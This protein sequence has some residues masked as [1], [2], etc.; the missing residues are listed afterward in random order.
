MTTI[1][2]RGTQIPLPCNPLLV[3]P[4][5][6]L[7]LETGKYSPRCVALRMGSNPCTSPCIAFVSPGFYNANKNKHTRTHTHTHTHTHTPSTGTMHTHTANTSRTTHHHH[8]PVLQEAPTRHPAPSP[9]SPAC[10]C[11][12]GQSRGCLYGRLINRSGV[13]A[14]GLY[15]NILPVSAILLSVLRFKTRVG[16]MR[17]VSVSVSISVIVMHN[18]YITKCTV[19]LG[20]RC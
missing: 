4:L 6:L 12:R 1:R 3:E 17:S 15:M 14:V 19:V 18:S 11:A 20:A 10:S 13:V 9:Q 16:V 7:L 5:S 2:T 8:R